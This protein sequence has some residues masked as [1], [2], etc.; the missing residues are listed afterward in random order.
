M[1]LC[2][3]FFPAAYN[4]RIAKNKGESKM[5][6]RNNLTMIVRDQEEVENICGNGCT[7]IATCL[8]TEEYYR[9]F[10]SNRPHQYVMTGP[11]FNMTFYMN[12]LKEQGVCHFMLNQKDTKETIWFTLYQESYYKVLMKSYG[13]I[14]ED[15]VRTIME[16]EVREEK[17]YRLGYVTG[18][19]EKR[20]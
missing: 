2:H 18:R 8:E 10:E 7:W 20:L 19:N 3:Y 5:E 13:N 14:I 12:D 1:T 4:E 16:D 6:K 9:I 11:S 17:Q 15:E